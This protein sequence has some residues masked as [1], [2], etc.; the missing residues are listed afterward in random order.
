MV[1][2]G[3]VEKKRPPFSRRAGVEEAREVLKVKIE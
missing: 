1:R 2:P 3:H